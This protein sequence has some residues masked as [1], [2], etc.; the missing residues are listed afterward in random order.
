MSIAP[1]DRGRLARQA[2]PWCGLF[3]LSLAAAQVVQA[4]GASLPA[5][6]AAPVVIT[7]NTEMPADDV[8]SPAGSQSVLVMITVQDAT[9]G[10]ETHML[11]RTSRDRTSSDALLMGSEAAPDVLPALCQSTWLSG[12]VLNNR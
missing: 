6:V 12:P 9:T 2:L 11:C 10:N 3:C 8:A 1:A 7:G 5:P 4:A